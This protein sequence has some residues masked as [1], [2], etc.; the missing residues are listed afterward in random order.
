MKERIRMNEKIRISKLNNQD[1]LIEFGTF[2]YLKLE[3]HRE[4]PFKILYTPTL[5]ITQP[6]FLVTDIELKELKF[7]EIYK[8]NIISTGKIIQDLMKKMINEMRDD[9]L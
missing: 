2:G 9:E 8:D 6:T 1:L 5:V 3:A 7:S 4:I